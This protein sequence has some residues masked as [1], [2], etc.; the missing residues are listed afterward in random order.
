MPDLQAVKKEPLQMCC[1]PF[2]ETKKG[3][4]TANPPY[5]LWG[6]PSSL[7]YSVYQIYRHMQ[8]FA[9][10]FGMKKSIKTKKKDQNAG[11]K[12]GGCKHQ[13][14]MKP[15]S[16]GKRRKIEQDA[17]EI[18]NADTDQGIEKCAQPQIADV[19]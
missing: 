16:I 14:G 2:L 19:F 11:K 4:A 13:S 5:V 15:G 7:M 9:E 17:D 12:A 1:D 10:F 18:C 8:I 3:I 6:I